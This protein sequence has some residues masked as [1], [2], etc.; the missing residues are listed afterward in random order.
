MR[1]AS[2]YGNFVV[3]IQSEISEHYATGHQ[4]TLQPQVV[5]KFTPGGLLPFE[6]EIVL[7]HWTF[8]GSYQEMDEVTTVAPDY[9]IG[10]FD[11]VVAQ[12]ENNWSDET[13]V[14]VEESLQRLT[15]LDDVIELPRTLV[16]APWPRYD[17]FKGTVG[18]L[19][20]RLEEDG[21]DLEQVL[22]Y[23]RATQNRPAL[24]AALQSKLDGF[25]QEAGVE[26]EITA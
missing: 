5:A 7:N 14:A 17:D 15:R 20:K 24:I 21:H 13:R 12:L 8:N 3:L 23:E 1:F 22:E 9:R 18:A 19:M 4:R 2:K 11:S 10:V 6:R 16:P 25:E 26:E